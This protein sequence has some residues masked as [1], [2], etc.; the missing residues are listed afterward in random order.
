M[1][2]M[3]CDPTRPTRTFLLTAAPP[4]MLGDVEPAAMRHRDTE[5]QRRGWKTVWPPVPA[6]LPFSVS[7][8]LCGAFRSHLNRNWQGARM[9]YRVVVTDFLSDDL[10]PERRV[11]EGVA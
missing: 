2:E 9:T 8:C 4:K 5:A 11:L 7:L 3:N 6:S 10:E 1:A